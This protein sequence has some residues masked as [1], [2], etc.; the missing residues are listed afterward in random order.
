MTAVQLSVNT[1][2][3]PIQSAGGDNT[4]TFSGT[5]PSASATSIGNAYAVGISVSMGCFVIAGGVFLC[6][7]NT[8]NR[9]AAAISTAAAV[10]QL[11]HVRAAA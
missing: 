11:A 7:R 3:T 10:Q 9:A 6:M 8:R 2:A 4:S 5:E 1:T